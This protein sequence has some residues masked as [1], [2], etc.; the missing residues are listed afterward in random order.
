MGARVGQ[1]L[2]PKEMRRRLEALEE[3]VMQ[4]QR[5]NEY[6]RRN[7]H[8]CQR[9]CHRQPEF[10]IN[11]ATETHMEEE[12]ADGS[13]SPRNRSADSIEFEQVDLNSPLMNS[14]EMEEKMWIFLG[15]TLIAMGSKVSKWDGAISS[16]KVLREAVDEL[17]RQVQRSEKKVSMNV[18]CTKEDLKSNNF[19]DGVDYDPFYAEEYTQGLLLDH[20]RIETVDPHGL[21]YD[22]KYKYSINYEALLTI[23]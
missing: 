16:F 23:M 19:I 15:L 2:K 7:Q 6:L 13:Y 20:V 10:Y 9:C 11:E 18:F 4:L 12:I 3:Q 21:Y 17:R 8:Q 5:E 14:S 1:R 22:S